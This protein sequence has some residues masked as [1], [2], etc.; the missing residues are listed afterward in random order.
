MLIQLFRVAPIP[1]TFCFGDNFP[2]LVDIVIQLEIEFMV[3]KIYGKE[4]SENKF[5]HGN[6]FILKYLTHKVELGE[7][8]I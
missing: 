4:T 2:H 7:V 3:H 6:I 1:K 5:L 8:I